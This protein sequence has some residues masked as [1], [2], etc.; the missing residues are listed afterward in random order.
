[1]SYDLV[2]GTLFLVFVIYL[3]IVMECLKFDSRLL[4][5]LTPLPLM[6][7]TDLYILKCFFLRYTCVN[8]VPEKMHTKTSHKA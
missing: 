1:M 3:W 4:L 2:H 7:T 6:H 8:S 5:F